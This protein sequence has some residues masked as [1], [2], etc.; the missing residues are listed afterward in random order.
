MYKRR[1]FFSF[2]ISILM[3]FAL[4]PQFSFAAD[5]SSARQITGFVPLET[6]SYYY[7]GDPSEQDITSNLPDTLEVYLDGSTSS[8]TIDVHWES[9]EDFDETEFYFYSMKPVWSDAY[10]LSPYLSEVLDVPWITIY[11]QEPL[12]DTCEPMVTEDE[13][14]AIYVDEEEV[15]EEYGETAVEEETSEPD[16]DTDVESNDEEEVES[17]ETGDDTALKLLRVFADETYAA[18]E[19][20]TDKVYNYLTNTMGLNMAAACGV[21]TNINAE[22]AMSPIN[23]ENKY[24]TSFGLTDREYTDRVDAGKGAYKTKSGTK[25]NFK[26]DYCGYG[27]CQWT[28]LGRRT[29]LLNKALNKGV[30]VGN[31][32]MQMEFLSDELNGSYSSVIS[33]LKSVPNN[34]KG[35]YVAAFIFCNSFEV[36]ANTVSTA[37]SRA[38]T[39]ISSGGYWQKYSGHVGNLSGKS[40]LSVT[41]YK[42]PVTLVSGKG[43]TV[44]GLVVSNYDISKVTATIKDENGVKKYSKSSTAG[45]KVFSLYQF[46]DDLLF[47]KL[48]TGTYTYTITAKDKSDNTVKAVHKFTVKSSGSNSTRTGFCMT[49]TTQDEPV[50]DPSTPVV[51]PEST[52]AIYDFNYPTTLKKGKAFTISGKIKS[53]YPIRKV[54][55]KIVRV[56]TG[57]VKIKASET[58][59]GSKKSYNLGN[60]DSKVK[61]GTLAKGTYQY[62]VIGKDTQKSKTLVNK[63][64]V[65]K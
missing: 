8:T 38:K 15:A 32:K 44:K 14:P 55:I 34:A 25:R 56:C 62:K 16:P 28:S 45:S 27:L 51:E 57:V 5:S 1:T 37:T 41:G 24:N 35:A 39:C 53:N 10:T 26:T 58:L 21:M 52:I 49:G 59:T 17:D 61:F 12:S 18:G 9:V 64:F 31:I 54:T 60:L 33:T 6:D 46:D 19:T 2:I 23:L 48:S 40:V 22:S 7:E 20:N 50:V 63:K 11:K 3:V 43:M 42:Y 30:S 29:N 4:M 36:P 65:V 47:S 13:V